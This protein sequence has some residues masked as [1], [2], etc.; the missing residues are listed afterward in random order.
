MLSRKLKLYKNEHN[1][2]NY[3]GNWK[4]KFNLPWKQYRNC[5]TELRMNYVK[6]MKKEN[7]RMLKE[8]EKW[9]VC[10]WWNQRLDVDEK[11]SHGCGMD[12]T[13][14]FMY[15]VIFVLFGVEFFFLSHMNRRIGIER[16]GPTHVRFCVLL[17][18]CS[19]FHF[20]SRT[21]S[22]YA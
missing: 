18:G 13:V 4:E 20:I 3:S 10:Y 15:C 12:L 2:E 1:K 5:E 16:R 8:S 21:F 17:I 7:K 11:W 19:R 9:E 14:D 6:W 22:T